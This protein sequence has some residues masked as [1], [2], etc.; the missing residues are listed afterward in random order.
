MPSSLQALR[1]REFGNDTL[2]TY[3]GP[4][5]PRASSVYEDASAHENSGASTER[6]MRSSEDL[7]L[8]LAMTEGDSS[9]NKRQSLPARSPLGARAPTDER[10]RSSGGLPGTS[11][12]ESTLSI[13]TS[14][15]R[16]PRHNTLQ[17]ARERASLPLD[18]AV[19]TTPTASNYPSRSPYLSAP[20]PLSL[21][22][23][24]A[25]DWPRSPDMYR[26]GTRRGPS[27]TFSE[28]LPR[29]RANRN[30]GYETFRDPAANSRE[31]ETPLRTPTAQ[32]GRRRSD[33]ESESVGSATAPSTVWDELDDLKSRIK[34]LELTGMAPS[35]S[36]AAMA[37]QSA[38]RPRT[39]TTAP[40]TI[41]SSPKHVRKASAVPSDVTIGGPA[42]A[43]V[44]PLLHNA[45]TKAKPLLSPSLYRS[46]EATAA[47]ALALAA[48]TGSSGP[49]GT[50]Y[51]AASIISSVNVSDRQ[52]RRKA[53][54][55]CRNLTDLCI[56]L[57]EG[58]TDLVSPTTVRPSPTS[59]RYPGETPPS[60]Y[61]RRT[62]I[63][64]EDRTLKSSP[65]R[66]FTRLDG[67]RSSLLGL[68]L[69]ATSPREVAEQY[70]SQ[71][72]SPSQ[73]HVDYAARYNRPGT[74]LRTRHTTQ[75]DE[76]YDDPTIR[77]P[78][79][80]M[81]EIG[82]MRYRRNENG[83][84]IQPRSPGLREALAARRNSGIPEG[85][86]A[87]YDSP[88]GSTT[89]RADRIRGF[90]ESAGAPASEAGSIPNKRRR[91]ITS[92]EQYSP[93]T[94]RLGTEHQQLP[95]RTTSLSRRRNL[96][97]E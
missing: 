50:A 2:G 10:P 82:Q 14:Q 70:P 68:G 24:T 6:E 91:R 75:A 94:P 29:Q 65:S 5:A 51:S 34:N 93:S 55:M 88:P 28:A 3:Q 66:T 33:P 86:V 62:S 18:Y 46:L 63:D 92:L 80:A 15:H 97:V 53:D 64:P 21:H 23:R 16:R 72:V 37:N 27:S 12:N 9:A 7:F 49:Q 56:A 30:S 89:G 67:R 39:A 84:G 76:Q 90:M 32:S 87:E 26:F 85:R 31:Q 79:R 1:E 19:R 61:T 52:I 17:H 77:A 4:G 36:G 44:H 8:T 54:S 43:N 13:D 73:T 60:R 48:M 83:A 59:S 38:D 96:I 25:R 42:A 95:M 35:T 69:S 41:S 71:D 78:S 11:Q 20:S 22:D 45:L 58:K 47:D 40:T 57:C 74:T 81:T